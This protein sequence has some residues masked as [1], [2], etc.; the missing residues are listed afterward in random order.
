MHEEV[1]E[2]RNQ[3]VIAEALGG[4]VR[5][6][7]VD[8]TDIVEE[9]R[10]LHHCMATSAAALGRTLT[11]TAMDMVQQALYLRKRTVVEM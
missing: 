7:A 8:T 10:K 11:V 9:A 1:K 2:M 4:S 5:I 3:I 6:H